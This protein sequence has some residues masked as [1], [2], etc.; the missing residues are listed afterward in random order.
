M[1]R[2]RGRVL[3]TVMVLAAVTACTGGGGDEGTAAG[4]G[5]VGDAAAPVA[6]GDSAGRGE[7]GGGGGTVGEGGGT[8]GG[9]AGGESAAGAGGASFDT[10]GRAAFA[11]GELIYTAELTVRVEDVRAARQR[12]TVLVAGAG[13]VVAAE[14][15]TA[16]TSTT[17]YRVPP[18]RFDAVLDGMGRLGKELDRRRSVDDVTEEVADVESRL[19]TQRASV[20]RVRALLAEAKSLAEIVTVEAEVAKREAT[21]ESLQARARALSG[22]VDLATVTL[23]LVER[24]KDAS[25]VDEDDDAGF[26]AGLEAG[27]DAFSASVLVILTALGALLPFLLVLLPAAVVG[28]VLRSRRRSQSAG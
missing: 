23:Q 8:V 9:G 10:L 12:A 20:A 3:I 17:T 5:S 28:L 6:A 18:L 13:G 26:L 2:L 1:R 16:T 11:D 21:L 7:S 4:S 19:A 15:T 24:E 22:Q 27:W 25:K 14:A